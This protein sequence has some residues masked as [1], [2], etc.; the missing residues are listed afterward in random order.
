[1]CG[2]AGIISPPGQQISAD[3]LREM[4]NSLIHRGPDGEGFWINNSGN[5]GFGHR[6][7]AI[8]DLSSEAAQPMHYLQRY[9]IVYNGEIY[10]YKELRNDLL[11]A[12]YH[13]KTQS[14]TEVILA[15][16]DCY[17]SRCLQYFDGM[18]A[19]A[20]WDEKTR[21]LF[22]ARDRFGEKPFYF[23]QNG[24]F[25]FA[26]EMK[27]LWKAGVPKNLSE[28]MVLNYLSIGQLQNPTDKSETFY[29]NIFS[30]PPAHYLEYEEVSGKLTQYAYY[31]IDKQLSSR[32]SV[33]EAVSSLDDLMDQSVM[34]RLRSD[35]ETGSSLS[36]GIDS[37]T[38]AWY[39]RRHKASHNT[40]SAVFP[41]FE[42]NEEDNIG[43]AVH[44]LSLKSN[45][46]TPSA[47]DLAATLQRVSW[48]QEEP[49]SSASIFAQYSVFSRAA[50]S[51]IKVLLDGQGADE[52]LA[53]YEKYFHWYLQ[54]LI[55][56]HRLVKAR[57]EYLALKR[58]D[59]ALRWN[60]R[61]VVAAFL[62]SHAAMALEK[63]ELGMIRSNHNINPELLASL[64]GHEWEGLYKP[65]VTKLND[66]LYFN[67]MQMGLEELL[68]FSDR[69]AMAH[70]VEVRLPFLNPA[71]VKFAFSLPSSLKIRDG[72]SKWILRTMMKDRLPA[73]IVWQKRKTGFEPPQKQWLS[74]P[75]VKELIH[76]SRKKLVEHRVLRASV[77]D[78]EVIATD[79]HSFNNPDWRYLCLAQLI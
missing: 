18:F 8:I 22:A 78:K 14:D 25:Y 11:K 60:F 66:I 32:Y 71:L 47:E 19:F 31:D 42:K 9:T 43:L 59:A 13:F 76:L 77:L 62:P 70:S 75:A 64:K 44:H 7:L 74:S 27:A 73:N 28:K 48:H 72:Y 58:N 38:I 54:D 10:N 63:K 65:T 39:I 12:G 23:H 57:K 36:G 56:H 33:E 26:S 15:A 29:R 5:T 53:G 1:M 6:R 69:N 17:Q 37:S 4:A 49:F 68:R 55:G 50:S 21:M 3:I 40:F 45:I 41:G 52:I 61:N 35:V 20:I 51:G 16:Y 46:V 34:L 79:A 30:L 67:T 24:S 2:I